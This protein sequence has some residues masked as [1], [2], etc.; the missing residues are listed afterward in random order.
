MVR[1]ELPHLIFFQVALLIYGYCKSWRW[2]FGNERSEPSIEFTP[3]MVIFES[4]ERPVAAHDLAPVENDG[5][6]FTPENISFQSVKS[7]CRIAIVDV[8]A[9]HDSSNN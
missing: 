6:V 5:F 9:D 4:G 2:Y 1:A 8:L 7:S 3:Q